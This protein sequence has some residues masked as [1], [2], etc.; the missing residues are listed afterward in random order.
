MKQTQKYTTRGAET[1]A[2]AY[3]NGNEWVIL[4]EV[5]EMAING[6]QVSISGKHTAEIS[7]RK[8]HPYSHCDARKRYVRR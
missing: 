4:H 2:A 6:G 5:T 1:R 8:Y 7:S 3:R